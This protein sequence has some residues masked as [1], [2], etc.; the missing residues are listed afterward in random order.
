MVRKVSWQCSED[1]QR[2]RN[3]FL[4]L[5]S[6]GPVPL[7]SPHKK[8]LYLHLHNHRRMLVSASS[9]P[10][11][12]WVTAEG[13]SSLPDEAFHKASIRN[14]GRCFPDAARRDWSSGSCCCGMLLPKTV[15]SSDYN[16]LM[17]IQRL[18]K[19]RGQL[20]CTWHLTANPCFPGTSEQLVICVW[21]T[22]TQCAIHFLWEHGY[23]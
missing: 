5:L 19:D 17:L 7:Q 21:L 11:V 12:S 10:C 14:P 23:F 2:L 15:V 22:F 3:G 6:G 4:V 8:P 13:G 20:G 18:L 9:S 16:F 1:L